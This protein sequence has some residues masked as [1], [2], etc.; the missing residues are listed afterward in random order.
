MFEPAEVIAKL[1]EHDV[2]R[3]PKEMLGYV[4]FMETLLV[5][6]QYRIGIPDNERCQSWNG[7]SDQIWK[8]GVYAPIN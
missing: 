5:M 8:L 1:P 7:I 3:I 2:S 4:Q 6:A